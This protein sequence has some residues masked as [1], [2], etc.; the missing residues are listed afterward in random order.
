MFFQR[1][2]A[3][4][5]AAFFLAGC[6]LFGADDEARLPGERISVLQMQNELTADASLHEENI[7]IPEAWNNAFWPQAGGYPDH[8]PGHLLLGADLKNIWR[9][10][11]GKGGDRRTPLMSAPVVADGTV[12]A[13]DAV[14]NVT[15]LDLATGKE[16]W[17]QTVNQRD[18]EDS[19]A[20]GGGIAYASG[21]L[22]VTS[23][24]EYLMS[25]NPETGKMVWKAVIPSPARA[26][27][28]VMEGKV[29]LT[30][31]DNRMMVFDATDG[32][33]LW[34]YAGVSESTNLLG[35]ASPAADNTLVVLPLSSGEV[36]GLRPE[37]GQ[38]VWADSL[39]SVRRVGALSAISDIRA[40]P[41]ISKG[42]VYAI[43]YSGR[44]VAINQVSGERIWQRE[45]GG[46]EMPWVAGDAVYVLTTEQQLVALSRDS[47]GIYWVEPLQRYADQDRTD[48]IIWSGPVL[49]G[50]RIFVVSSKGE[51]LEID[52]Q[53]GALLKTIKLGGAAAVAPIIAD[54]TLLVLTVNGNIEAYR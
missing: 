26:A 24:Y 35:S 31:L 10:S 28:T 38:V 36:F 32:S 27:P 50:G 11:I 51:M 42:V 49:A 34:N 1:T 16:K 3:F 22:Y 48:P 14:G 20:I 53:T 12:F 17:R 37:N 21:R 47:G 7:Y 15:A 23:G 39:S 8:A 18:D 9:A 45:I 43:S 29:Y 4:A 44:L 52:P 40:L 46:S 6:S 54:G 13:L 25:I 19:G 33:P 30:T 5:F 41:V 2:A